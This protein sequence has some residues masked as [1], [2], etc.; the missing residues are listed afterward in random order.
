M[1][2][3]SVVLIEPMGN[4]SNVFENYMQLPLTGVLYLGTILDKNGYE[5][6]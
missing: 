5:T 6:Y 2:K 1:K 3:T 4:T